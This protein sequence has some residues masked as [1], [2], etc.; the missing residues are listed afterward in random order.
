M[1]VGVSAGGFIAARF[2]APGR[3]LVLEQLV[4]LGARTFP[5]EIRR[6]IVA[7]AIREGGTLTQAVADFRAARQKAFAIMRTDPL[8]RAALDAALAEVRA[9]TDALQT[10]GQAIVTRAVEQ[11][12]P[13]ARAA[14]GSP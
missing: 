13:E 3:G 11:A 1:I 6:A 12:S 8:D 14:I 10:V 7:D 2:M 9:K 5:A 4:N